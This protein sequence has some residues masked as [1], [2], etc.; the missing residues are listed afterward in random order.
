MRKSIGRK[1]MLLMSVLGFM[2]MLICIL[3]ISALYNVERYNNS[4]A[5]TFE[6]YNVAMQSGDSEVMQTAEEEYKYYVDRSNI[7]VSGTV[8]FNVALIIFSCLFMISNWIVVKKKIADPA[9][10]ASRQLN[11]IVQKIEEEQGDLTERI[12]TKSQDEI[13]QL[14]NGINGF[15]DSLQVLMK[16]IKKQ[17]ENLMLSTNEVTEQVNESNESA[18]NVSAA[19]EEISTNMDEVT[20]SLE[21]IS[22]GSSKVLEKVQIMDKGAQEGSSNMLNIR[23]RAR[24][25]KEEAK[26]SKNDA[27]Q[28]FREVGTSLHKAVGESKS[29]EQINVL[30]DNILNI[31]SQTNLLALNASIEA[32]RAGE[33]GKGFAVVADEIRVLAENSRETA[34]DIQKIS[35]L[36]TSAVNKLAS[37]A[38]RML[39]F[40]NDEVVR[41]YDNFVNII[42]Q[43]EQDAEDINGLLTEFAKQSAEISCTMEMMN[44]GIG[45]SN[46]TVEQSAKAISRV[47]ED[48]SR[49]VAAI[50]QIQHE[51]DNN[52]LIAKD[53]ENEVKRFQKV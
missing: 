30:T 35:E 2:L 23:N 16:K 5:K 25:M 14:V 42:V 51:T 41:D 52:R 43:Y 3:N 20:S 22:D 53:L 18:M 13:G 40:V 32:A 48:S 27:I 31:A 47:A 33:A 21:H 9:R 19:T 39:E 49:L 29:V 12:Q 7:R 46:I 6:N 44:K 37:E 1:I 50:S 38:S 11:S 15:I 8:V 10:D 4:L 36:V 26:G 34:S 45:D 24:D 17:S 28:V